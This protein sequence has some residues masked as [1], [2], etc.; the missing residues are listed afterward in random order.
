MLPRLVNG[1]RLLFVGCS[2]PFGKS[3]SKKKTKEMTFLL[4]GSGY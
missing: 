4:D 3:V 1:I 2:A